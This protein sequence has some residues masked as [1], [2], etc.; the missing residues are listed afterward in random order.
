MNYARQ[1]AAITADTAKAQNVDFL[2]T[3]FQCTREGSMVRITIAIST[4][5]AVLLVPNTGTGVQ[6]NGTTALTAGGLHTFELA[7]D[8]GRTWNVQ[9]SN[10]SG[11]TCRHLVVQEIAP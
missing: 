9:T 7:L 11:T 2:A 5:V 10:A 6:L 8:T 3:D 1:L 4:A